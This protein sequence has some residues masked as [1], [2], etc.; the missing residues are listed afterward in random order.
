MRRKRYGHLAVLD[1]DRCNLARHRVKPSRGNIFA[2]Q[3]KIKSDSMTGMVG[4]EKERP[5]VRFAAK[6]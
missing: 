5:A 1:F 2:G 3:A 4:H 6:R